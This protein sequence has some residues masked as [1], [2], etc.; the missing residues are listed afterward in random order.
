MRR[1][2]P[3]IHDALSQREGFRKKNPQC[4]DLHCGLGLAAPTAPDLTYPYF[5][6]LSSRI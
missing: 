2:R 5:Q 4:D 6:A 3:T 1:H